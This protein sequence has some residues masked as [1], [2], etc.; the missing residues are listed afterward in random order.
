MWHTTIC[1]CSCGTPFFCTPH[2]DIDALKAVFTSNKNIVGFLV[3]PIQG[4]AGIFTPEEDYLR[5]VQQLCN[6][7]DVLFIAD[8]IQTGIARTGSLLAVCGNCDCSSSCLRQ[9][10]TFAAPDILILGKAIS[11]GVYPVSAIKRTSFWLQ[12]C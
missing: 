3:E 7:N 12:S 4:E 10:D 11:G 1:A 9:S 6:Q 5:N 8:E 2:N